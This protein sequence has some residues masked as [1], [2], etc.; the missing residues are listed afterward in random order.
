MKNV[1]FTTTAI[2]GLALSG[3][4]FA[5]G[6][7]SGNFGI[8]GSTDIG[9]NDEVEGGIFAETN[10]DIKA[11]KDAGNGITI[12]GHARLNF[13]WYQAD[14]S[15][16]NS[17]G[18]AKGQATA[19][20]LKSVYVDTAVG[21]L[22][23]AD[24][25]DGTGASDS[26]YKDRDGMAED[27]T[28]GDGHAGLKWSGEAGPIGYAI[29]LGNIEGNSGTNAEDHYTIG[30][31]GEFGPAT[32]GLGWENNSHEGA[33]SVLGVSLDFAAG[34]VDVGVS[35]IDSDVD[36]S[37]GVAV[38]AEVGA[39]LTIGAYYAMNDSEA[40]D[41]MGVT[42]DYANGPFAVAIDYDMNRP[43]TNDDNF[44]IDVSYEVNS[45]VTVYA[46]YDDKEVNY[47]GDAGSFYAGAEIMVADGVN[48]TI[49]YAQADEIGGPEFKGG[50]S[51]FLSLTY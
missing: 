31:G 5:A 29:D 49:A 38:S 35:Y 43:G 48:A 21:K 4:A 1:L 28:Q 15:L 27:M 37:T 46:G 6:H 12:G 32:V 24:S 25:F 18:N 51:A 9:Y 30:L 13:D 10:I 8:S 22:E 42:L 34:P 2:A 3:A 20:E 26:F 17:D 47:D 16:G 50:T 19:I 33:G 44:E 45:Y 40:D 39:G 36:T 11:S 23:Y 41:S 14:P 7:S